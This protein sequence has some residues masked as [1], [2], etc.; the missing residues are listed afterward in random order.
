M[1]PQSQ[2]YYIV[3]VCC[4]LSL[5]VFALWAPH[6]RQ[7]KDGAHLGLLNADRLAS[8]AVTLTLFAASVMLLVAAAV[9]HTTPRLARYLHLSIAVTTLSLVCGVS[10]VVCYGLKTSVNAQDYSYWTM[11]AMC[12]SVA[13]PLAMDVRRRQVWRYEEI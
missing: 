7:L 4:S 2:T 12:G 5:A 9:V 3:A 13:I 11:V 1:A 6:W 10:C 8:D